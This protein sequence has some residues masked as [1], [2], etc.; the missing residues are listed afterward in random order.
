MAARPAGVLGAKGITRREAEVLDVL[1]E[2]LTNAE[3]A[4]RLF[5]SER[6][7]E[8]HVASLLRKFE[9]PSRRVLVERA[10]SLTDRKS[11]V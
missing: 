2:G 5:V 9:A 7:V 3:I 4:A 8:S 11:V 10:A 6:T 1:R